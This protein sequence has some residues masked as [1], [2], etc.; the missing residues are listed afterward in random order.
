MKIIQVI[1]IHLYNKRKEFHF[2]SYEQFFF[3]I[4]KPRKA[5]FTPGGPLQKH[6]HINSTNLT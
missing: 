2:L 5:K 4:I 6:I 3:S 1:I